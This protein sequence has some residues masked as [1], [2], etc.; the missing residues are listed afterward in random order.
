MKIAKGLQNISSLTAI[1]IH[2]NNI[3]EEAADDIAVL[4]SHNTKLN[5][6]GLGHIFTAHF[7]SSY[8][9]CSTVMPYQNIT[10]E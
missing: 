6:L 4:I 3:S 9:K 1:N 5:I 8:I 2:H 10:P 7:S